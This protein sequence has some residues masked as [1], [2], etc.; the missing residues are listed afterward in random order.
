MNYRSQLASSQSKVGSDDHPLW[1]LFIIHLYCSHI[2]SAKTSPPRISQSFHDI[3]SPHQQSIHPH[4]ISLFLIVRSLSHH[5]YYSLDCSLS[6]SAWI[7][8]PPSQV[9][10]AS[11]VF[12]A[13]TLPAST[14]TIFLYPSSGPKSAI[15]F[16]LLSHGFQTTTSPIISRVI[17][18]RGLFFSATTMVLEGSKE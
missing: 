9:S 5:A 15:D 17:S 1:Q 4:C 2:D 13:N 18:Y 7:L 14:H 10:P 3:A 11:S 6:H 8:C 16:A 12:H